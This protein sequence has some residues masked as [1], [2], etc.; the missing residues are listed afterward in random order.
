MSPESSPE[1]SPF[2]TIHETMGDKIF[3]RGSKYFKEFGPGSPNITGVQIFRY[4]P[5]NLPILCNLYEMGVTLYTVVGCC[6]FP[7]DHE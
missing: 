4:S 7:H 1:S 6:E 5:P 2:I 3:Q